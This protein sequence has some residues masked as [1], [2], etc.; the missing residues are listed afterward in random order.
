MTT[1]E[2]CKDSL[3]PDGSRARHLAERRVTKDR[4]RIYGD[5]PR[6]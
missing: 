2:L 6:T 4:P 5:D 1:G 3:L